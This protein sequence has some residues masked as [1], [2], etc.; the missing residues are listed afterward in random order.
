MAPHIRRKSSTA[1]LV[2]ERLVRTRERLWATGISATVAAIPALLVGYTLGYPSSTLSELTALPSDF[3]FSDLLASLF[4]VSVEEKCDRACMLKPY[5]GGQPTP[6][7]GHS[8]QLLASH[9]CHHG[10][11]ESQSLSAQAVIPL[12][13]LLGCLHLCLAM[14]H[15]KATGQLNAAIRK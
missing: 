1:K 15:S 7:H 3:R 13:G 10:Q 11:V 5:N 14:S 8:M 4:G 6:M 2:V 12:L 9:D